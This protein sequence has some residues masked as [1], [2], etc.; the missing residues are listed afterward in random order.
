[1]PNV[2]STLD[3]V[4]K[5]ERRDATK[6]YVELIDGIE[7]PKM[8]PMTRHGLLQSAFATLLEP[9]A[10]ARGVVGTEIR[11]WLQTQG[12]R[13]TSLVPDIAFVSY[14]RLARLTPNEVQRIPFAPDLAVEIRSPGDRA[15]NIA[16]K[17]GLYL[18]YGARVVLD[19]DPRSQTIV[20]H[21]ANG[22]RTYARNDR[23][24]H[25]L[26]PAFEFDIEQ[27]LVAGEIRRA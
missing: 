7:V 13:P 12:D 18:D 24:A 27:L 15:R 17:V 26:L 16:R 14:E 11:F 19:V 3:V 23:F 20:A 21:D 9:W 8:S 22:E 4:A 2:L 5:F 1:V 6:P 10:G 25:P